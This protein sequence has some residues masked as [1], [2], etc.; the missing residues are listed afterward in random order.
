MADMFKQHFMK[1]YP[2][3]IKVEHPPQEESKPKEPE[4]ESNLNLNRILMK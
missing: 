4:A 1:Y 2:K 3:P